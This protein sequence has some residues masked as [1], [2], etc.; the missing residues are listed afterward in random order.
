V[1]QSSFRE[2]IV[3]FGIGEVAEVVRYYFDKDSPWYEVQAFTVD[4][5]YVKETA[6][7]GLPV[8]P[9]EELA[10]VYVSQVT[11]VFVAM[12]FREVNKAR[13]SAL[14]RVRAAGYKL[15]TFC[16]SKA[17]VWDQLVV[18]P[19]TFIME[20]NVI[21]PFVSIG[22]NCI[23]WSG[24]HIGHHT[25][26]GDDCFIASHVVVSGHV[27]IGNNTFIGVNAT[28]RDNITIGERNVIGAGALILKSTEDDA[29][30]VGARSE[31]FKKKSFE[32][33]RI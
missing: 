24:N 25:S 6:H 7:Q 17:I 20:N 23:L 3:V 33:G 29:V 32:L 2:P 27:T 15:A 8:I 28:L 16:H 14:A 4:G 11:R 1:R 26:I 21:Q 31:P 13:T 30:Y 18:R 12:S 9:F 22:E 19:N 5:E 10:S